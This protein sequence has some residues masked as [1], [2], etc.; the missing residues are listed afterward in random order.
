[1]PK[2]PPFHWWRTVFYLIPAI[3]VYTIVLGTASIVSSLF[4]RHPNAG[5]F[6]NQPRPCPRAAVREVAAPIEQ[7]RQDRHGAK[8]DGVDGDGGDEKEDRAPPVVGGKAQ[9]KS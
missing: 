5:R 6:Q 3:S 8:D 7:T 9:A 4:D 1:M 2:L